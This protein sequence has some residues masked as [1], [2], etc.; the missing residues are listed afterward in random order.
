MTTLYTD[1]LSSTNNYV[2]PK[3]MRE[4][5]YMYCEPVSKRKFFTWSRLMSF[6]L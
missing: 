4:E 1:Y 6:F 2:E 3:W 5:R